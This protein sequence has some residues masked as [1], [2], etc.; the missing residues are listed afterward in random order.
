M[1]NLFR[2][3]LIACLVLPFAACK[4]AEAP[5]VEKPAV[6]MPTDP[7]N[8]Q[9]WMEYMGDIVTRISDALVEQSVSAQEISRHVELISRMADRSAM[10]TQSITGEAQ[11]LAR[12]ADGLRTALDRFQ[13]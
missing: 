10:A 13:I 3:M 6:A 4:K 5:K 8:K 11:A 2:L 12:S 1:K 7:A 9:G